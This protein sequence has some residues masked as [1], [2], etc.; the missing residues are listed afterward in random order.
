[1]LLVP[2]PSGSKSLILN[3]FSFISLTSTI[4]AVLGVGFFHVDFWRYAMSN[5]KCQIGNL[6]RSVFEKELLFPLFS[7]PQRRFIC[8]LKHH[9][10]NQDSLTNSF[11]QKHFLPPKN[12]PISPTN[13]FF[14]IKTHIGCVVCYISTYI[15]HKNHLKM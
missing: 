15:Y 8:F 4:D 9:I 2:V 5:W 3:A 11:T 14:S 12:S 7:L 1:M 6:S 10:T 13:M